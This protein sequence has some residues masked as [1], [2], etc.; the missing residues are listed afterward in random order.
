MP[1]SSGYAAHYDDLMAHFKTHAGIVTI[2]RADL[3]S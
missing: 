1:E 2:F 3:K